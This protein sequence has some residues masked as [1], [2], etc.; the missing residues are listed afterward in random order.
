[1]FMEKINKSDMESSGF[2]W[3]SRIQHKSSAV[4]LKSV[5][6]EVD[7]TQIQFS[8]CSLQSFRTFQLF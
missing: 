4:S 2:V 1:M 6:H 8:P 7:P 5:A 3:M